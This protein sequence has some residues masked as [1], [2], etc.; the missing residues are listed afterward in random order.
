MAARGRRRSNTL[1]GGES[2]FEC[3]LNSDDAS[4]AA[5]V[6][7]INQENRKKA[8]VEAPRQVFSS[9]PRPST[10]ISPPPPSPYQGP[11]TPDSEV[12]ESVEL[13]KEEWREEFKPDFSQIDDN[14]ASVTGYRGTSYDRP[15]RVDPREG[16]QPH[17]PVPSPTSFAH[18]PFVAGSHTSQVQNNT[19]T[20]RARR[21]RLRTK[22]LRTDIMNYQNYG[23][24]PS[25][26]ASPR[27]AP[28]P[29]GMNHVNGLNGAV[30]MPAMMAGLPTPAGHQSD[31]N[32]I[33]Q[34]VEQLSQVLEENRAASHRITVS[35]DRVRE[36][37]LEMDMS[38]DEMIKEV[39]AALNGTSSTI[40][41]HLTLLFPRC[42]FIL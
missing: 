16:K 41:L 37:A 26:G 1:T 9:A 6:D 15:Q 20:P 19:S 3:P 42:L 22:P 36:R 39:S 2:P 28:S 38:N 32:Y 33:Q 29:Q 11:Q 34:M 13:T 30:G 40:T 31:L 14:F 18:Q 21:I 5:L 7:L 10:P 25:P 23:E 35:A 17:S 27:Q 8:A 4:V 12:L 24:G